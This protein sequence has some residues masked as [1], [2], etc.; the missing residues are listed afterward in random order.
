[1]L[2]LFVPVTFFDELIEHLLEF[3]FLLVNVLED[4]LL[5][6]L[7]PTDL[8]VQHKLEVL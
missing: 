1:M 6:L 3:L 4:T 5:V 7:Q 2:P 8:I